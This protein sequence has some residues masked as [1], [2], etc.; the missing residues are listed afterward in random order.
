MAI[1]GECAVIL[2]LVEQRRN[3]AD[4]PYHTHYVV[5]VN[6]SDKEVVNLAIVD[7]GAIEL[8]KDAI[9]ATSINHK[10]PSGTLKIEAGVVATSAHC[11][12][13]TQHFYVLR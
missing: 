2:A 1:D 12:T 7:A 13:S 5:G 10:L 8:A 3:L 9:A 11:T 6:M 4:E